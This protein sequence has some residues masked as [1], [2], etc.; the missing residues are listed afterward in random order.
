M[1]ST[2]KAIA[3]FCAV[4]GAECAA[5]GAATAQQL[6]DGQMEVL[7]VILS[8]FAFLCFGI[9]GTCFAF[10]RW[11]VKNQ[12]P[13]NLDPE[14]LIL[15]TR[16]QNDSNLGPVLKQLD[17]MMPLLRKVGEHDDTIKRL[18]EVVGMKLGEEATKPDWEK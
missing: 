5:A 15:L 1:Y 3:V 11:F 17:Q 14:T 9:I 18:V 10:M 6:V 4:I 13:K 7:Q 12:N 8:Y 2:N 16:I